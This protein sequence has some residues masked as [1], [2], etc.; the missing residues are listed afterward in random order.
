M[1]D[2]N[3]WV[4][5]LNQNPP[6][7]RVGLGVVWACRLIETMHFPISLRDCLCI[8]EIYRLP[9]L[10][11]DSWRMVQTGLHLIKFNETSLRDL[12]CMR[13]LELLMRSSCFIWFL[14]DFDCRGWAF[15][16]AVLLPSVADGYDMAKRLDMSCSLVEFE[17]LARLIA[18]LLFILYV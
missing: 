4:K 3:Y 12:S 5:E 17:G 1:W 11:S 7:F 8:K 9:T 13:S 16:V 10:Q 18:S 6:F 15:L 2:V 14:L